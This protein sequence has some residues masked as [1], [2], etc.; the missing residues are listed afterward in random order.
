MFSVAKSRLL[1]LLESGAKASRWVMT[2]VRPS[3]SRS[4]DARRDATHLRDQAAFVER[5][6]DT[7]L[8]HQVRADGAEPPKA[9][10]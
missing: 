10:G 2:G 9:A 6:R 7:K 3:T 5:G 4:A 1:A 8:E